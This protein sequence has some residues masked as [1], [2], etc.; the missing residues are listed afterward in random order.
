MIFG[1]QYVPLKNKGQLLIENLELSGVPVNY[2]LYNGTTYEFF[3]M[4]TIVEEAKDSQALVTTDLNNA[5][6]K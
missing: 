2:K 3:G 5:F 4:A 6:N 1:A